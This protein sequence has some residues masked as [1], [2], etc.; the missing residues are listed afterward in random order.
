MSRLVPTVSKAI[1]TRASPPM[2]GHLGDEAP[3]EG[4][5]LDAVPGPGRRGRRLWG[6]SPPRGSSSRGRGRR[7]KG[8]R[9]R[10]PGRS[11][12]HRCGAAGRDGGAPPPAPA[13]RRRA[14]GRISPRTPPGSP[15]KSGRA[16]WSWCGR[17]AFAGMHRSCTASPWP[18]SW[19]RSRGGGSSSISSASPMARMP[20]KMPSSTPTTNTTGNSRPLAEC[21]V[22]MDHAVLVGVVGI[23]VSVQGDL[24]QEA[25]QGGARPRRFPGSSGWRRAARGRSPAGCG[26]PR[27]SSAPA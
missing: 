21:M 25:G 5:V 14:G 4:L 1:S 6:R 11:P 10:A 12:G 16:G 19:P 7:R 2:G 22:I 24:V 26:L 15:P 27:C 18:A 9:T 17:R 13:A 23:Q 3:A 8:R 20:G